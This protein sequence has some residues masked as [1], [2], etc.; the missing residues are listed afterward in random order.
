[1]ARY[2]SL[3]T[4]STS[5]DNVRPALATVLE[6]CNMRVIYETGDYLVAR[7][8]PGQVS[9]AQLV[10]AEVLID[11]HQRLD[12]HQ[13]QADLKP[14]VRLN[15]VIKNEELPLKLNNHCRRMFDMINDALASSDCLS[16]R[17]HIAS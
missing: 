3:C 5:D 14:S 12:H 8:V 1:M 17:D 10:T 16:L 7:E 13:N 6:S 4:I 9:Y 2:T 11:Q 15:L